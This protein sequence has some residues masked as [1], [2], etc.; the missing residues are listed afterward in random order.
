MPAELNEV[1]QAQ[2]ASPPDAE[3]E[4]V[5]SLLRRRPGLLRDDP[6]LLSALGLRLDAANIVDF[7]P[8]ALSRVSAAHEREFSE[9]RR[10]EAMARANF[11]AQTQAHAAV[12]DVMGAGDLRDLAERVDQLARQ[13]FGLAVG[14]LAVEVGETPAGWRPLMAG[15]VDLALGEGRLARLGRLPT[16]AGLFGAM[17]PHV[18]SA[19]LARLAIR[20]SPGARAALG[21]LGL[22]SADPEAF[23]EDM[24]AELVTFLAAVIERTAERCPRF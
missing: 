9:R 11:A 14:V 4:A 24:G 10:L 12:I 3:I 5:K 18:E 20:W 17:A 13:R 22:G 2:E 8:V 23:T 16:A 19:A 7:G 21:M 1:S 15:Q 6:D